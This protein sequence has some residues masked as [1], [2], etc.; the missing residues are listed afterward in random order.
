MFVCSDSDFCEDRR[1]KGHVGPMAGDPAALQIGGDQTRE[2]A[3]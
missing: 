2:T 3:Q 1:A